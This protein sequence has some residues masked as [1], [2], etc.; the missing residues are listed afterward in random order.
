MKSDRESLSTPSLVWVA[1][2]DGIGDTALG[3]PLGE[4]ESDESA[5]TSVEMEVNDTKKC[6]ESKQETHPAMMTCC[7]FS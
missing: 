1:L 5:T 6:R 3:E 4:Q 7:G 2:V